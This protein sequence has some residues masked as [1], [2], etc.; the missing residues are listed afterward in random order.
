MSTFV[1]VHGAWHGAWC[2]HRAAAL[3]PDQGEKVKPSGFLD[4]PNRNAPRP[5][6]A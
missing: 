6:R 4:E 5:R 2:R 3:L 1:L